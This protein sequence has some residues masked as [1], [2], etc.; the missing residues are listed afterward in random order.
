MLNYYM[1]NKNCFYCCQK[2][3]SHSE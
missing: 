1:K 2:K 3:Q